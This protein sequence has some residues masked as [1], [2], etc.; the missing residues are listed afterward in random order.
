MLALLFLLATAFGSYQTYQYT[1]SVQF[2]GASCHVPMHPEFTAYLH[3]PHAR[4]SCVDCH[5]GSGAE[6][7]VRS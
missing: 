1:D 6:S 5:V 4:V 3:S 7:H 2:C